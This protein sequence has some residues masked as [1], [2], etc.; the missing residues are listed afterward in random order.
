MRFRP[1]ATFLPFAFFYSIDSRRSLFSSPFSPLFL[2]FLLVHCIGVHW[3]VLNGLPS[4]LLSPSQLPHFFLPPI[5]PRL[6][7]GSPSIALFTKPSSRCFAGGSSSAGKDHRCILAHACHFYRHTRH[8]HMHTLYTV[9]TARFYVNVS[10]T[11]QRAHTR[12]LSDPRLDESY[13]P[14]VRGRAARDTK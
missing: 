8:L 14:P 6:L 3:P 4:T 5:F 1:R 9:C 13:L 7:T 12:I 10:A 11:V 2:K